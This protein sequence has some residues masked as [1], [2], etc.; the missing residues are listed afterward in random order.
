[1][2]CS[3]LYGAEDRK[4]LQGHPTP[5]EMQ[6]AQQQSSQSQR[7]VSPQ[8]IP[9]PAP[10]IPP[11]LSPNITAPKISPQVINPP[12]QIPT[13][14]AANVSTMRNIPSAPA[15]VTTPT[16]PVPVEIP[17]VPMIGNT[18]GKVEDIGSGSDGSFWIEVNDD[19]FGTLIK[20]KIRNPRNTP[21]VKQAR[22]L[23]FKDI[24]IGNTVNAMFHTEGDDNIAN[25][26][27][28]MTEE[29]IELMKQPAESKLTISDTNPPEKR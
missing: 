19:L 14:Q 8:V 1:L 27:N 24:K 4:N 21:I 9:A 15:Y 18:I 16:V 2:F 29:E 20:V 26:I 11:T 3:V 23:N 13:P 28:V 25:F 22:I 6:K 17:Q 12:Q 10:M 5:E 7:P